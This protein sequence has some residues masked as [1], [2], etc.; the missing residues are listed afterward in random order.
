MLILAL[1]ST[2]ADG[3]VCLFQDD[4]CLVSFST[5]LGHNHSETLL[6]MIEQVLSIS[7]KTARDVDVF[8]CSV[9]PGSY[10]GIRIGVATV[11][12]LAFAQDTPCVGVSSLEALAQ[13]AP[14]RPGD[15]ICASLDARN[16]RVFAALFENTDGVV[17]R[18]T[19]DDA[20]GVD[21]MITRIRTVRS[22]FTESVPL[23][24]SVGDGSKPLLRGLGNTCDAFLPV[25]DRAGTA[26]GVARIALRQALSGETVSEREL[27]PVYL[28]SS[29]AE[30]VK[31][32]Q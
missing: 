31:Y 14:S 19:P 9:G 25:C 15:L 32:G 12:G 17:R 11:K 8:A 16:N 24:L 27:K 18:L 30:R 6:P 5:S 23:T 20:L 1:D 3:S 28:R 29:Q 7:G 22:N 2:A 21:E 4:R 10:T 26:L 13:C